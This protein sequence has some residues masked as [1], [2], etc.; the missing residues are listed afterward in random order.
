MLPGCAAI[1]VNT[2]HEGRFAQERGAKQV[3]VAGIGI[4]PHAFK[5]PNENKI[6]E[7]HGLG[8]HWVVGYVGRRDPEKGLYEVIKAMHHVWTW[9]KDVRL[10]PAGPRFPSSRDMDH[11]RVFGVSE[12]QDS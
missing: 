12:R 8:S 6:R 3:A 2:S 4:D 7:R 5:A 9:N 1:I 10:L 11:G